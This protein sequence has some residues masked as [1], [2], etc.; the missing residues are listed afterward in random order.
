MRSSDVCLAYRWQF[1]LRRFYTP[2]WKGNHRDEV[3][4]RIQRVH[5]PRQR[6]G[7]CCCC[8]CCCYHR[9]A[10]ASIVTALTTN[11]INP[12]ISVVT[13]GSADTVSGLVVPGTEIDFGAFI[14]VCVNFLIVAFVVFLLIK[15]VNK[16]QDLGNKIAKKEKKEEKP[17]PA[18]P[19]CLEEVKGGAT[20]CPHCAGAFAGPAKSE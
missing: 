4:G 10:F 2:H 13:G 17:A 3:P 7:S 15:A 11:I 9:R 8:C 19:F 16:A 18:C 6:Y 12:L 5:Q 14:S 1:R 20:R